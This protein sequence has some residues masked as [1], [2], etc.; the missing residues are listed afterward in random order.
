MFSGLVLNVLGTLAIKVH[1]F[2]FRKQCEKEWRISLKFKHVIDHWQPL[3]PFSRI[4]G[5]ICFSVPGRFL[6]ARQ[7]CTSRCPSGTFS[8]HASSQCEDCSEGCLMC[9]DAQQCQ[10]CRSGLYL[11][12]KVC[13]VEC[14]RCLPCFFSFVDLHVNVHRHNTS[15]IPDSPLCLLFSQRVSSRWCMPAVSPR[16][17]ILPGEFLSLSELWETVL[18]AGPLLQ[19]TLS[20]GLLRHKDRM[21]SLSSSM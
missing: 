4:S 8:N 20:R 12:N 17:C 21:P 18:A 10:R 14:P 7:S 1:V 11:H 9:Q 5:L 19:V 16:V 6:T 2:F 3:C 15:V 13:V